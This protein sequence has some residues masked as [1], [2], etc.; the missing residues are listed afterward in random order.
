MFSITPFSFDVLFPMNPLE[1]RHKPYI[2]R[3][4]SRYSYIFVADSIDLSS[5]KFSRWA[6][7]DAR[8]LKQSA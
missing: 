7:E 3:N 2:A 8:V 6:P 4:Y 1:Y 5:F